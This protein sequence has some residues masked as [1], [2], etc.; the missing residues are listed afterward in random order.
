MMRVRTL[1]WLAA[2]AVG[3]L[4]PA[5][6]NSPVRAQQVPPAAGPKKAEPPAGPRSD[7][8]AGPKSD[9]T[10][11]ADAPD[12]APRVSGVPKTPAERD[13]V[14]AELY[15]ELAVADDL[16]EA[17]AVEESLER[18]W[19][20]SGSATVDLLFARAMQAAAQKDFDRA[21]LFLD[22][23][24]EQAPDFTEAWSRRAFIRFQRNEVGL[25]LGDLRR[26]LALDPSNFKVLDGL[27]QVMRDIGEKE[28]ALKVLRRLLE[29]H[30]LWPGA[31]RAVEDLAREVEGQ[32]L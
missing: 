7:P 19:L 25:A 24:V 21:L 11:K 3:L 6:V 12:K 26:A 32:P 27:A 15:A 4:A 18:V 14:L 5:G 8:K 13:R 31:E 10:D 17:K 22:H 16:A 29:V 9:K 23:V 1:L 2:L 20:H 28:G 30:P